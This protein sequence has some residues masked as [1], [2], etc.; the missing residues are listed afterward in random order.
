MQIIGIVGGVASGKSLVARQFEQLGAGVLG[1]DAAGYD[2]LRTAEVD[3]VSGALD[4]EL[5]GKFR[6][7][8]S[9]EGTWEVAAGGLMKL[10]TGDSDAGLGHDS[11]QSELFL[12]ASRALGPTLLIGHVGV[13]F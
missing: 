9:V 7:R 12:A 10:P 3:I 11:T 1:A 6:L 8:E 2:V 5:W 13:G 4:L